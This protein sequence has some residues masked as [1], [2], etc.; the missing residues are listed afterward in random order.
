LCPSGLS[1]AKPSADHIPLGG[2]VQ[3]TDQKHASSLAKILLAISAGR[4]ALLPCLCGRVFADRERFYR[5]FALAGASKIAPRVPH[6]RTALPE[7][8][9]FARRIHGRPEQTKR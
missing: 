6:F 5:I 9:G 3:T 2:F 7:S 4:V 8:A 1:A